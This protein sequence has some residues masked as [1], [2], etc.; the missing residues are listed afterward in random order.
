M[1]GA[2]LDA[3]MQIP[4]NMFA[5]EMQEDSQVYNDLQARYQR[6]FN[7]DE[8]ATARAWQER[9][10]NTA[11]QRSVTDLRTAG[12][13]PILAARTGGASSGSGPSATGG[14]AGS[15]GGTASSANTHFTQAQQNEA[16]KEV[17]E[18]QKALLLEQ[19]RSEHEKVYKTYWEAGL[20]E[21]RLKTEQHNT[22]AAEQNADILTA[23]AKGRALEGDIDSTTYGKI[24][25]YI[26][27]AM[28]SITGG[29][30]AYGNI[31]K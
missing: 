29:S 12:L 9:M 18:S 25:R 2:I 17:M 15:S 8:A 7:S 23:N 11:H 6:S 20:E 1:W 13:N 26:D 14:M 10:S 16:L 5:E 22:R 31:S 21:Q 27:R 3:A 30:S 28:R 4:N 24:M 19:K